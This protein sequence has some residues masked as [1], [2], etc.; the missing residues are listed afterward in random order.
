MKQEDNKAGLEQKLE[1]LIRLLQG[2]SLTDAEADQYKE[3]FNAAIQ[4]S[5]IGRDQIKLYEQLDD[6][7][8]SRVEMLNELSKLLNTAPVDSRVVQSYKK[9]DTIARVLTFIIGAILIALG[10]AMIIIPAPA[11]F[12]IYTLFY[13]TP[14]DGVTIMDVISL[15]IILTGVYII[16]VT[17]KKKSG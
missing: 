3:Q 11:S 10:F 14:D 13:F 16:V 15:L 6:T 4:K 9:T 8:L 5:V 2:T 1:E 17:M 12:E 7:D